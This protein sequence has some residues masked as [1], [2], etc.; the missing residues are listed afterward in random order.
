MSHLRGVYHQEKNGI[1]HS[2]QGDSSE[3]S[4]LHQQPVKL[5][6]AW[7]ENNL[8]D[9]E[10]NFKHLTMADA[11][12]TLNAPQDRYNLVYITFLIHGIGVLTSWNMFIN[13]F[14]YFVSFKLSKDYIGFPFEHNG[15]F[16]QYLTFCSQIPAILFSWI[17][18]F[19]RLGGNITVRIVWG[20][21]I[22][23][24]I[25]I[26]TILMAMT[27]TGD[28]P[29]VFFYV[30][31]V[32]VVTLNVANAVYQ[33]TVFGMAAKLPGKYTGA[34]ILGNNICG[35]FASSVSLLSK[36]GTKNLKMAA[37]YYF[38]TALFVLLICFDTYFALPLNKYY[39]HF[40]LKERKERQKIQDVTGQGRP[41][42]WHIFKRALPQLVNVFMLFFVTLCIFPAIQVGIRK[43]DPDFFVAN[44]FYSDVMCFMTFN[45]FALIGS[46]LPT[47]F[48]WP[49]PRWLWLP[50]VLRF[51]YIPL[52]LLCNYQVD[53]V[54]RVLP[55]LIKNDW[56]YFVIAATMALTS[57]YYSSLAMMYAPGTVEEKY[58]SIAGMFAA[59]ALVSGI[60]SGIVVTFMWPWFISHVGN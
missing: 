28:I 41:P 60:F 59:A 3:K 12:L 52:F 32:C 35:T 16:M 21:G 2:N 14:D 54:E 9:D 51:L 15:N 24:V 4:R 33:N 36:L 53:S 39:R 48:V 44:D 50:I 56:V 1:G 6:P 22:A 30:T 26:I 58:A 46:W 23:I 17:N 29:Y 5:H 37:I 57:G 40:D 42:Y 10:L 27:D 55:I 25:F 47:Y 43:S 49:G 38:I 13:A 19:V 34:V 31:L 8:P 18:I 45:V 7:E 20:I 11:S